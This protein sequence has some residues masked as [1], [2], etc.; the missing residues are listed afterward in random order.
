MPLTLD[1]VLEDGPVVISPGRDGERGAG[2]GLA[3]RVARDHLDLARVGVAAS[4]DVQV[5]HAVVQQLVSAALQTR[6]KKSTFGIIKCQYYSN[7]A[8]SKHRTSAVKA[9]TIL[10]LTE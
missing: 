10:Y 1:V 3:A 2:V 8:S 7:T 6:S 4:R 5:P 9:A